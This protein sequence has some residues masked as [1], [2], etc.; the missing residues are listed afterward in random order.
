[1]AAVLVGSSGFG[2]SEYLRYIGDFEKTVPDG[3]ELPLLSGICC[4]PMFADEEFA[5]TRKRTYSP[6]RVR[7]FTL[8]MIFRTSE[9]SDPLLVHLVGREL[10][11]RLF[12]DRFECVVATHVKERTLHN[13]IMVNAVSYSE[14][15]TA[16]HYLR[17]WMIETALKEIC[18]EHGI[19]INCFEKN[20]GWVSQYWA[21]ADGYP[22]LQGLMRSASDL[23][24]SLSRTPEDFFGIMNELGYGDIRWNG[25]LYYYRVAE[26]RLLRPSKLGRGYS[27]EGIRERILNGREYSPDALPGQ[28]KASDIASPFAKEDNGFAKA[29]GTVCAAVSACGDDP[30]RNVSAMYNLGIMRAREKALQRALRLIR[31]RGLYNAEE[32]DAEINRLRELKK[33]AKRP[34][35]WRKLGKENEP[36]D[37]RR[38]LRYDIEALEYVLKRLPV[39]EKFAEDL[40]KGKFDRLEEKLREYGIGERVHG[41]H[42][43]PSR[44]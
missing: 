25:E 17:H 39:I 28:E 12:S 42:G 36:H 13:H 10:V 31:E 22:T 16:S 23:A 5:D 43:D 1:M 38:E 6:G 4:S 33:K 19:E 29:L 11:K 14:H 3:G 7:Y 30:G 9:V 8:T 15:V 40:E 24:V 18:A 37:D 34:S 26:G 41:G 21:E 2:T 44:E 32:I 35:D 20:D 27:E